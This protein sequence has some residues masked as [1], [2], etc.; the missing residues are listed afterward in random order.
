MKTQILDID[1]QQIVRWLLDEE[2]RGTKRFT[3]VATRSYLVEPLT[4][5]ERQGLGEEEAEDLSDVLAIGVLEVRQQADAGWVLRLRV[6]DRIGPR[7][8]VEEEEFAEE[9]EQ[10]ELEAFEAEFIRP[11]RGIADVSLEVRDAQAEG[12]FTRLF[13]AM[14]RDKRFSAAGK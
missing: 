9:E 7:S 12:R 5:A 1:A 4:E 11:E 10:I 3:V 2:R 6:E 13:K 8:P 14:L